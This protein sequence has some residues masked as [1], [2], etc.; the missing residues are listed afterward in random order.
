MRRIAKTDDNQEEIVSALRQMGCTVQLLHQVGNG[1]PDI[2][3]G[4]AGINLLFEIKDGSKPP[5]KRKLTI[6]EL[7]W[8]DAWRGQVQVIESVDHAVR[9]INYVRKQQERKIPS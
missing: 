2:V 7:L 1:C 3:V 8:H 5:S 6:H 9:T 4:V